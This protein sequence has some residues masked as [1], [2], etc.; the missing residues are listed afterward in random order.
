ML[1]TKNGKSV[2]EGEKVDNHLYKMK[3]KI[4]N[5]LINNVGHIAFIRN[6]NVPNTGNTGNAVGNAAHNTLSW[7]TWHQ[8]V[9]HIGYSR[10]QLLWDGKMADRFNLDETTPNPIVRLA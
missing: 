1:I 9:S 10:L 6:Y 2:A 4:K 8:H 7:E 5:P 3:M